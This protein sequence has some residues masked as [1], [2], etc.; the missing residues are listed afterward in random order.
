M[1]VCVGVAIGKGKVECEDSAFFNE[2]LVDN[3]IVEYESSDFHCVGA[4]D[5]VG[6]NAGG[7]NASSF[8]VS[9]ISQTDFS[10]MS[11]DAIHAFVMNLNKELIHYASTMRGKTE[12]ATTLT[13]VVAALDGFYLIHAGNTRLY[14]MQGS[15]LK[16]L[17]NDHTTYNW[18]VNCGQYETAEQCNKS[19]INCCLGGGSSQFANGVIVQKLFD[20]MLPDTMLLTSDGVHEYVDIDSMEEILA[21]ADSDLEAIKMLVDKADTNG[22]TDDKTAII[23]RK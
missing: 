20:D 14:I 16:Q 23:A 22:S 18:L 12:M 11:E 15:Y 6:G 3:R 8:V 7:R 19:E 2:S 1:N 10:Q 21:A 9:K 13:C 17:T 4:A 5:G